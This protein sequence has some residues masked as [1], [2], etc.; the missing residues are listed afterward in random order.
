MFSPGHGVTW[1]C[2]EGFMAFR[3]RRTGRHRR[4]RQSAQFG[5]IG[6]ANL[7]GGSHSGGRPARAA[8]RGL[9]ARR[10]SR[11]LTRS[12]RR[13]QRHISTAS[14]CWS[15]TRS[16]TTTTSTRIPAPISGPSTRSSARR[17]STRPPTP[18]SARPTATRPI[19]SP[20]STCAPSRW[21]CACPKSRRAGTTTF[22]SLTCTPTTS[23]TWAA[24][25]QATAPAATWSPDPAGLVIRRRV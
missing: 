1:Q 23:A 12:V 22:S 11:M 18:P 7:D 24:G 3:L 16:S 13:R 20:N 6:R 25:P 14:R 8:L 19:R 2:E 9:C 17:V 15:P 21:F 5:K 10:T 4:K